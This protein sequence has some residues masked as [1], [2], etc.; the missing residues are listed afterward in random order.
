M[1]CTYGRVAV[2]A[3]HQHKLCAH[4]QNAPVWSGAAHN[5]HRP[6]VV[7]IASAVLAIARNLLVPASGRNG[8]RVGMRVQIPARLHVLENHTIAMLEQALGV[9]IVCCVLGD[10]CVLG[11][12]CVCVWCSNK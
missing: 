7:D 5:M 1:Q 8:R 11:F 2:V 6:L 10:V 12:V 4:T 9:C 3:V